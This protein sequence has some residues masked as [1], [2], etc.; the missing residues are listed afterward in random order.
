M[1]AVKDSPAIGD[2]WYGVEVR[3]YASPYEGAAQIAGLPVQAIKFSVQL[4]PGEVP[5]HQDIETL[6]EAQRYQA[7][8][9]GMSAVATGTD[10]PARTYM[11]TVEG[12]HSSS[13]YVAQLG[14]HR[15][16]TLA[17]AKPG[18]WVF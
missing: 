15:E 16:F 3:Q 14:E 5:V 6:I 17:V 12:R 11:V 10:W 13:A 9:T 2:G 1:S 7:A 18:D 4:N 8:V